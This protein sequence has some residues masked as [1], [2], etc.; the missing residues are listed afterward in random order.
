[1]TNNPA[2]TTT[3]AAS[4]APATTSTSTTTNT[5][6]T[7]V[8]LT[9][10]SCPTCCEEHDD[11]R[12]CPAMQHEAWKYGNDGA[13]FFCESRSHDLDFCPDRYY[14]DYEGDG[15]VEVSALQMKGTT[16][17]RITTLFLSVLF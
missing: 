6:A 14:F 9:P 5:T 4:A 12:C 1:M 16:Q 17:V 10:F 15:P 7:T 8:I 2:A 11:Y 3:P 13:C